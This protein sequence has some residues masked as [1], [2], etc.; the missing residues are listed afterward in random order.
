MLV[1]LFMLKVVK[2]LAVRINRR[3]ESR[4]KNALKHA[5]VRRIVNFVVV[6]Y[7]FRIEPISRER[8]ES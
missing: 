7:P 2:L 6:A 1:I 3:G 8:K 4:V 5:S